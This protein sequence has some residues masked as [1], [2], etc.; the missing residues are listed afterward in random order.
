MS[1]PVS[2][3]AGADIL[4]AVAQT[5]SKCSGGS[6]TEEYMGAVLLASTEA[7]PLCLGGA[8]LCHQRRLRLNKTEKSE[9]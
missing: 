1:S 5:G 4:P 2:P 7:A 9:G 6:P 3:V 8:W